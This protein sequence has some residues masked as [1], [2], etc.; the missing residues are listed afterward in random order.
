MSNP[1]IY[2]DREG[3][4]KYIEDC[5]VEPDANNFIEP[6]TDSLHHV[7]LELNQTSYFRAIDT[8]KEA[9][10]KA[11]Q[12]AVR[13]S[14]Q[15]ESLTAIFGYPKC[16][17]L[18]SIH[19]LPSGVEVEVREEPEE[20]SGRDNFLN[21]VDFEKLAYIKEPPKQEESQEDHREWDTALTDAIVETDGKIQPYFKILSFLSEKY[22]LI[23][24]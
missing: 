13:F 20:N 3:T 22:R 1:K 12:D 5:P 19:D 16:L 15:K 2:I 14:D 23:R 24:R 18:D 9:L 11:K 7:S 17:P 4:T 10:S 21:K 6:Q 8:Y